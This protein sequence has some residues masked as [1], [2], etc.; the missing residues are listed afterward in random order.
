[1]TL[2]PPTDHKWAALHGAVWSGGSFVYVPA[3]VQVDIP[4]QSYFRLNAP[5]AGPFEHTMIIVEEGAKVHFIEG[6]SAPKYDVSNLHAGAVELFVKDNAT[7]RYSTIENWSKNMYNLNTKRCVVGKGGTIEW[8]SGSFGSHVSCLYP[9][10]ILNGEGAHAEFT[11]VTFA[12]E[13]QFLDTGCKVV[14]NAPYTTSNVNSKSIS[15]SGGAA[16]Y[17]GLLKIGPN[18]EHAKATVSCE[19]LMLDEIS[20]SD[21]IP[22]IIVENDNVDLGHEA[23]IGRI[24][25][26]AIFYLMTRGISEEEARAMLV[27]GFVEPISKELPLEY[28]VE[29]NNLINLELEGSIG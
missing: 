27:R 5:G 20:Q 29:M 13:G 1:M 15:K 16:I 3:G 14:H 18:A 23:K 26:E 21:T 25:D 28:A 9:M 2:I 19:S 11:G 22:A 12:G 4:L 8:V 10:S 24:S 7:L 17:R 6:C